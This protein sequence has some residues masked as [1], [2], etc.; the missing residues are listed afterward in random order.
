MPTIKEWLKDMMLI[1]ALAGHEERMAAYFSKELERFTDQVETDRMGNVISHIKGTDPKAPVVMVFA[2]MDQ[3]GFVIRKVESD[4][5]LR[6]ERLGG[7]PEKVLPGLRVLVESEEGKL[8]PGLIGP[9]AH[10][11]TPAEEKYVVTPI[12]Q[13]YVDIGL[14]SKDEAEALGIFPGCPIVYYPFCEFFGKNK[15]SGT[16]IDNRGG[17]A[18]LLDFARRMH[19]K[20]PQCTLYIVGSVLEEFN[21]RGALVAAQ[22]IQPDIAV[23]LD[24]G[25]SG[26][27]PDL[28]H[29][30]GTRL[31]GGPTMSLYNFHGRGTLNGTLPHP[32][33]VRSFLRSSKENNIPLQRTAG[34]GGL[35]DLSYVQ[36]VGKGVAA[37]DVGFPMRYSHSPVET[38]DLEDMDKLSELLDVTIRSWGPD[39]KELRR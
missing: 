31:S 19:A 26:D 23:A 32:A 27:T 9:K 6:I 12:G 17:C 16:S 39:M 25:G 29:H 2:H 3:L 38:C 22:V 30:S 14:K 20:R 35:T 37:I 21:L 11:V 33:I 36:L 18:V 13:L 10:H 24:V 5:F 34:I 28:K 8:Y 4:G 7:I 15:V 1:P